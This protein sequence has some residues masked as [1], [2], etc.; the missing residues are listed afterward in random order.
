MSMIVDKAIGS[1][2]YYKKNNLTN[3]WVNITKSVTF[4]TGADT[5]KVKIDFDLTDGG[6][7]DSDGV[8]NGTIVD[9]GGIA[10]NTLTPYVV[11]G[12]TLV[13]DASFVEDSYII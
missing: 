3:K 5:G 11:E 10:T 13:G 7:F 12:T 1:Y 8:A 6:A 2:S 4:L 9:P